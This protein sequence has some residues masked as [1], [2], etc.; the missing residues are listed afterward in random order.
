MLDIWDCGK[1]FHNGG[2]SYGDMSSGMNYPVGGGVA[3][4]VGVP[5]TP[6]YVPPNRA[7]PPSQYGHGHHFVGGNPV[8]QNPWHHSATDG[9]GELYVK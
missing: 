5:Q 3:S 9:Y 6:V 2:G 7:M 8:A 1:M 4:G